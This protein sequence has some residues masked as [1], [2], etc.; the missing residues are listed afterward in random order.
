MFRVAVQ[1]FSQSMKVLKLQ[2][3]HNMVILNQLRYPAAVPPPDQ[4]IL[5]PP[6][7]QISL[8][9]IKISSLTNFVLWTFNHCPASRTF[10]IGIMLSTPA[11]TSAACTPPWESHHKDSGMDNTW[12]IAWV[13]QTIIDRENLM[14]TALHS[15]LSS[16]GRFSGEFTDFIHFLSNSKGN[17]Y[18]ALYQ[19]VCL[20]HPL[21]G[22][23]TTQP[24]QPQQCKS[25]PSSEHVSN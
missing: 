21:M 2:P 5:N 4:S 17:G 25:Q 15:L 3:Y 10:I 12:F 1:L 9:S 19:M 18:L 24:S 14:S 23:N 11:Y 16:N 13:D 6:Q 7:H 8:T 22:Q 20:F